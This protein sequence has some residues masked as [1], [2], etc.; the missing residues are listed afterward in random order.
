MGKV[1]RSWRWLAVMSV[2]ALLAACGG[3]DDDNDRPQQPVDGTFV[4][5]VA[6][7]DALVAVV[8]APPERGRDRRE[9]TLYVS[10]G[11]RVSESLTGSVQANGFRATSEDR[12][13]EATGRLSR[14]GATGTVELPGGESAR[15]QAT[16]ATAAAGLYD[17]TVSSKGR[18]SGAS[19][20]GVGLESSSTLRAPG[21]GRLRFADGE[22]R[23]F[24][25]TSAS[26][27]DPTRL[28]GGQLRLIVLPSGELSGAG[29]AQASSGGDELELFIRSSEE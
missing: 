17:L 12:D 21:T 2:S 19:A 24:A 26:S 4:G 10:D 25:L 23:K 8:A 1:P 16:R 27:G 6:G 13:A 20:S 18:L 14:G 9:V 28:R 15:F 22:R 5:K 7:T 29:E 3:D 11:Q